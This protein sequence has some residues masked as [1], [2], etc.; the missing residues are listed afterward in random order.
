MKKI[1][2]IIFA[3]TI[4]QI[5][6]IL[7]QTYVENRYFHELVTTTKNTGMFENILIFSNANHYYKVD[8][9]NQ[10]ILLTGASANQIEDNFIPN[11]DDIVEFEINENE[12][13][14][15]NTISST[16]ALDITKDSDGNY[17]FIDSDGKLFA[18]DEGGSHI[19]LFDCEENYLFIGMTVDNDYVV[20]S[21]YNSSWDIIITKIPKISGENIEHNYGQTATG[22]YEIVT[23]ERLNGTKEII[24]L[25]QTNE[26][27]FISKLEDD[28]SFT[29]L[30]EI[31]ELTGDIR[32][33]ASIDENDNYHVLVTGQNGS[34]EIVYE[35]ETN[36]VQ[37]LQNVQ[38]SIFPNPTNGI[39]N[40]EIQEQIEKITVFDILGK[41]ILE[42]INTEINLTE[43]KTGTY[44]LKIETEN[45]ILTE[46]IVVE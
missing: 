29:N 9:E 28:F 33:S 23:V 11:G 25:K 6:S 27:M 30:L 1:I 21:H 41:V 36:N 35:E 40:I 5:P 20:L 16:T 26:S 31:T 42:T 44:F 10:P 19:E 24:F 13:I 39:I 18:Y 22:I 37:N 32:M 15:I 8:G 17:Y 7:A 43:Q 4:F 2:T 46:K 12:I 14:T 45:G 3:I 34:L 38:I